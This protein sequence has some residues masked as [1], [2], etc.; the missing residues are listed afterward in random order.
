MTLSS[1][2]DH[3]KLVV[4]VNQSPLDV[5]SFEG[6]EALSQPS[7][8]RIDFISPDKTIPPRAM[9]MQEAG[10]T[11]HDPDTNVPLRKGKGQK[12]ARLHNLSD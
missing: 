10:F 8:Y 6:Y 2:H 4:R 5:L 3:R 1:S 9:L 12:P 7:E 11:L